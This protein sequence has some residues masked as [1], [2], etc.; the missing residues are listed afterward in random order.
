MA[1]SA[2]TSPADETRGRAE[3][4]VNELVANGDLDNLVHLARLVGSAQDALNDEMVGRLAATAAGGLDMLDRANRAGV[5]RALPAIAQL[6]E[7][8]DMDNLVQLARVMGSAQDA[9]SDEMVGRLAATAAGGLDMLDRA[10]RSGIARGLPALEAFI[11]NGD[12]DLVVQLARLVASAQDALTDDMIG[13]LARVAAESMVL[14]DR[15]TR[16][17][18]FLRLIGLLERPDIQDTLAALLEA[19]A[20]AREAGAGTPS[21]G[22]LGGAVRL[23]SEPG[24]Q[25]ALRFMA[26]IS[27]ALSAR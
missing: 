14:V 27:Q 24:T 20:S 13:R 15:L 17:E 8:G 26:R 9:L 3:E 10:Q 4:L 1:Q 22:G 19:V 25:D 7:N 11:E 6:V 12:L 2:E 5:A 21:K 16:S 18:G 23:M